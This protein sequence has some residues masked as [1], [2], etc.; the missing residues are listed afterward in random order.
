M[1]NLKNILKKIEKEK[2]KFYKIILSPQ[3]WINGNDLYDIDNFIDFIHSQ[4]IN[5]V[6]GSE[7]FDDAEDYLITEELIEEKLGRYLAEEMGNIII[8]E[9]EEYN[10]K[11]NEI[12]FN[13]PSIYTIACLYEGQYFY[14]RVGI[15][16]GIN[17]S[18]LLEADKKLE[19][20]IANNERNIQKKK[21]EKRKII[22]QLKEELEEIILNDEEFSKCTN[23]LLRKNYIKELLVKKLDSHF[24][25]LKKIWVGETLRGIHQE[26]IDMVEILWRKIKQ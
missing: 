21:Q 19:E 12:D 10:K 18:F 17:E 24:E 20:I 14:I 16:R 13:K 9:I 3:A 6:F 23:K 11:V 22:I 4:K 26:P 15:D 25:P 1:E 5:V 8:N 7:L 2:V